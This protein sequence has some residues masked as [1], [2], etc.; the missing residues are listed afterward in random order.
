MNLQDYILKG[1]AGAHGSVLLGR[2]ME[3]LLQLNPNMIL[4]VM[5]VPFKKHRIGVHTTH[6]APMPGS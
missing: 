6:L 2:C 5:D 1:W 4:V 3:R